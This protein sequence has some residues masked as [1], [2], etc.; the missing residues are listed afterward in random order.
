MVIAISLLDIN[1]ISE[2]KKMNIYQFL[3]NEDF[4]PFYGEPFLSFLF[5]GILDIKV[6]LE[7]K[8]SS[9]TLI[10]KILES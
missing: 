6:F 1:Q 4:S 7:E 3:I 10:I 2:E 5:R 9:G 8:P